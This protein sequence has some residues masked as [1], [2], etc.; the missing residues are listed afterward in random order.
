LPF[1][2]WIALESEF[3]YTDRKYAKADPVFWIRGL[4]V[5]GEATQAE[6]ARAAYEAVWPAHT[7]FLLDKRVPLIP[8]PALSCCYV[9][10][11]VPPELS[12]RV[13]RS[14]VRLIGPMEREFIVW[15]SPLAYAYTARDLAAVDELYRFIESSGVC[16]WNGGVKAA[17]DVHRTARLSASDL[18]DLGVVARLSALARQLVCRD[19][20][21]KLQ[22]FLRL[23]V[24]AA[25]PGIQPLYGVG[26]HARRYGN[27]EDWPRTG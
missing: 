22:P 3:E 26:C 23:P 4:A 16:D 13:S 15:D 21:R 27:V 17:I 18:G 2:E 20:H 9:V 25:K 8:T 5:E 1:E 7:S 24:A 12:D 10:T 6:V 11:P 19:R 14:V